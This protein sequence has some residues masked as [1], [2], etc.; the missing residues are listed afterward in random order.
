[1][2]AIGRIGVVSVAWP[3]K[4]HELPEWIDRRLRARGLKA[5]PAAVQRL[6]ERV[7][8]NLLAAAQEVEKLV[9]LADGQVLDVERMDALVAN[10]ARYDVFRLSDAT[11]NGGAVLVSRRLR[12]LRGEGQAVPALLGMLAMQ[13]QRAAVLARTQ[14]RGGNVSAEFKAQRIWDTRQASY[15][16]A[17]QRHPLPRWEAFVG[18]L[19]RV[20]RIARS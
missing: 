19:G 2:E 11:L 18:V 4:P 13:L 5:D 12:G 6:A 9:L 15:L 3:V 8:G 17:L 14:A 1:S 7:E 20:D 10:S 16:R